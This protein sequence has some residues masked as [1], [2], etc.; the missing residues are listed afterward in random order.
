LDFE[1]DIKDIL[2]FRID[3]KKKIPSSTL[4]MALGYPKDELLNL[5]HEKI[6]FDF[7]EKDKLK[8]KFI[9]QRYKNYKLKNDLVNADNGKK[10]LKVGTKVNIPIAMKLQKEGLK[11]IFISYEEVQGRYFADD[12][13]NEKTGEI[14][15][16]SGDE[17]T[18]ESLEKLKALNIKSFYLSEIDGINIGS[19]LRNTI[20]VDKNNTA[21]E[22]IMD[23]YRILRPGEPPTLETSKILF[24]NLFFNNTRYDLSDV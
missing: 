15:F 13:F 24:N 19:Y 11:N 1:Y 6:K 14:Y 8:T 7:F 4:L 3:R 21:E 22:A 2:Y 16:E 10:V 9:P 5:F 12:I 17:V 23:I 18:A 20:V